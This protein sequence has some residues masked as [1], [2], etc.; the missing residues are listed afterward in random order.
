M[1]DSWQFVFGIEQELPK[2]NHEL[3]KN[4]ICEKFMADS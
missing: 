4:Q 2:K 1:A 3:S